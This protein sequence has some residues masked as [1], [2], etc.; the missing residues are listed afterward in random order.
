MSKEYDKYI[1][2]HKV[3]V[4]KAYTWLLDNYDDVLKISKYPNL[5]ENLLN[6]DTS[7]YSDEE[8]DAYDKYFYGGNRSYAVVE[9]FRRAWFHHIHVNPHHWQYWVLVN[10]D[11]KEGTIALDMPDEYIIEMICDWWSFSWRSG[12]LTEIF[13][14]YDDHK[15]SMILHERT[16]ASVE[17]ILTMIKYKLD[18]GGHEVEGD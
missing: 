10:D 18:E 6:H 4:M 2:E 7:K 8:Y 14:W 1:K 16:R 3:A 17:L 13:K 15:D 9:E 5:K 12:D 11:P